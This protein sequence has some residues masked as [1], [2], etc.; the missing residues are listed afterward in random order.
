[1]AALPRFTPRQSVVASFEAYT[2]KPLP[3]GFSGDVEMD[4]ADPHEYVFELAR[5]ADGSAVAAA[6]SSRCIATFDGPTMRATGAPLAGHAGTLTD[7]AFDRTD[8]ALVLSS[9]EDGTVRGWDLRSRRE[10]LRIGHDEGVLNLSVGCGGSMLA[11]AS[12]VAAHF[13][14]LRTRTKLG[15]YADNHTDLVTQ[16]V[17]NPMNETEVA[18]GSED[19]LVCVY[20]CRQASAETS[21]QC[22]LNGDCAVRRV[23]FFAP[24][25]EGLFV[26]TGSET[27]GL[28][29][30]A[31][32]QCLNPGT[33]GNVRAS[34]PGVNYLVD[35]RFEAC[36]GKL[37]LL[38][39]DYEGG[40]TLCEASD[41]AVAPVATLASGH[42]AMVRACLWGDGGGGAGPL[43]SLVTGGEDTR[44]CA[45]SFAETAPVAAAGGAVGASAVAVQNPQGRKKHDK[46]AAG[47]VRKHRADRDAAAPY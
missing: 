19:G 26:L 47:P 2:P 34:V 28:W 12:G 1:M 44:L 9:S 13:F 32:A 20:D 15:C 11:T 38:A 23:G 27:L 33:A 5:A 31:T 8:P 29:H 36:S 21:L 6:L 25:G 41:A 3:A 22:V 4:E 40:L 10:V 43:A 37:H 24:G 18:T 42:S 45:W 17:F 35:C 7:V 30:K 16:V 39:G 46:E 14:D